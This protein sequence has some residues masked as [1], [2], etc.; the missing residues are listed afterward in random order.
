[1]YSLL[2]MNFISI[3]LFLKKS[4][5]QDCFC[6]RGKRAP[7]PPLSRLG[8]NDSKAMPW[9]FQVVKKYQ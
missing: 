9:C 2:Y 3:N 6:L 1:M 5:L 7:M 4:V 8:Q